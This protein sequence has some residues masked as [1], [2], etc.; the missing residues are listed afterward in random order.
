[1]SWY[2]FD[3][4]IV[5]VGA[6]AAI[7]CALPGCFLVLRQ[8]SM[9]GDAIS[10]PVLQAGQMLTILFFLFLQS[11]WFGLAAIALIPLQAW[12]IPHLQKQINV[13]NKERIREVR[14]LAA[15]IGENAAGAT[16]LRRHGGWRYR[17]SMMTDQ[18]GV[19]YH[20][21]FRIYQKKFFMKFINNFITQLTPFLF[22][23]VGGYLVLQGNV[24]IGALVAALAAYKDLSSPWKELLTYYNQTQDLSLRWQILIEKFAPDGSISE[25]LITEPPAEIPHVSGAVTLDRV[26][27]RDADGAAIL[28]DISATI[29]SGSVVGIAAPAEEDRL[30]MAELLSREVTPSAGRVLLGDT[31]MATVHQAVL[32]ARIGVATS[33]PVTFRG[34]FGDN[35]LMGVRLRPME[36][37]DDPV[38]LREA[39]TAGNSSDA[40]SVNW[41]DPGLA[42]LKTEEE[43]RCWWLKLTKGMGSGSI[44]FQRGLDQCF[45]PEQHPKLAEKL[46][47]LRPDVLDA[48]ERAGLRD[49]VY[50]FMDDRFNDTLPVFENLLFATPYEPITADLLENRTDFVK[51]LSELD[52]VDDLVQLS[53]DVLDMLRSIFGRDGT[54]HPLFRR[55]GL[56]VQG[57]EA[58]LKVLDATRNGGSVDLS[59]TEVSQL[60]IIAFRIKAMDIGAAFA[61]ELKARIVSMRQS[62]GEA[63]R[64]ALHDVVAPLDPQ[65][66]AVGQTVL[67]NVLFG[68]IFATGAAKIEEIRKLATDILIKNGAE[69]LVIELIYDVPIGLGGTNLPAVFAEPLSLGRATIKRP[70]ILIMEQALS[71]YELE[72]KR[73]VFHNLRDL[74]PGTTIIYVDD[75]FSNPDVFDLHLEIKDGRLVSDAV[76]PEADV[77]N[78]V[79]ADLQRKQRALQQ[80]S[81]FSSLDRR[82]LRLLAF[83]ARWY[84]A[85][86]GEVVFLKGDEPTDGAYVMIEG[87]AGLYLPQE[88]GPAQ[89]IAQV[90]P[91]QI[92]GEL[93]LIRKVPRALTMQAETDITC[94]RIGEEE[95]MAVVENDAQ[96]AFK[97]LQVVAGYV[98]N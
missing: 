63:L 25:E 85:K 2:T 64:T 36:D 40:Y 42:G 33:R 90:G 39:E 92:V 27:V 21:R 76:A 56:D 71:S 61:D 44:L 87:E 68:R 11:V 6:L 94:L 26:T 12:L 15:M 84:E 95:F 24:S 3:T 22:Y 23:S 97:L 80:S 82:Q 86:A 8:M 93:G 69:D 43:L 73:A 5:I 49:M 35:V 45:A 59:P 19:L 75:A 89:A 9:M 67:E 38:A 66:F 1:M 30:A 4:W 48:L 13:L 46:V 41:V 47:A 70:D 55:L 16:A 17:L 62:H 37:A 50:R 54:D 96:T 58:A 28:E 51:L 34:T 7:A 74:L 98:S 29:P 57:Y 18:L 79:S 65:R 52:M 78:A 20:I 81:L 88:G 53:R 77:E 31:D 14:Q 60:G 72:T 91:G 32:A 83:G 10:Q